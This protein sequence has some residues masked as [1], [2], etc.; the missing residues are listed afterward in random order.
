[1]MLPLVALALFPLSAWG[2]QAQVIEQIIAQVNDR[3][4]T[5]SEYKRSLQSLREELSEG[6]AGALEI[7][8]RFQEQSKDALRDLI[9]RQLL[10]QKASEMGLNAETDVIKRLDE[11]RQGM[12]LPS[13]EALEEA[14]AKQGI[15]FEDFKENLR[16]DILRQW[17]IQREVGS[18]IQITPAEIQTYYDQHQKELETPEGV[19]LLEILVSTEE[20]SPEEIPALRQK[21]EEVLVKVKA[22]QDFAELARQYSDD[23]SAGRGGAIGFFEK[24]SLSPEIETAIASL[25][26]NQNSEIVETRYGFMILKVVS[27]TKAGIPT[28]TEAESR[29]NERLYL[30]RIQPALRE[31]LTRLRQESFIS[32]K[33]GYTDTGAA[34]AAAPATSNS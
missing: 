23:A 1:M 3:I 9:D 24:G 33:P 7:E 28:L 6:S 19:N 8:A 27:R 18:T 15:I 25:Q 13:M 14:A 34:P 26:N 31:Y 11:I 30:Q 17:V 16:D 22:G 2:L 21:A 12:N 32:V 5:L 4:I 20:K 29:I 10:V